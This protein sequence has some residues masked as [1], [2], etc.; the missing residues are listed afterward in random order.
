MIYSLHKYRLPAFDNGFL[1]TQKGS[2]SIKLWGVFLLFQVFSCSLVF[3]MDDRQS[4][5]EEF[6]KLEQLSQQHWKMHHHQEINPTLTPTTPIE[7]L[8]QQLHQKIDSASTPVTPIEH[9]HQQLH[10]DLELSRTHGATHYH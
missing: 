7:D 1:L 10:N 2:S 6:E 9:L 5:T 3:G 4:I 8:H